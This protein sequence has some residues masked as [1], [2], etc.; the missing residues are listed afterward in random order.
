MTLQKNRPFGG[1][2]HWDDVEIGDAVHLRRGGRIEYAGRVDNRTADGAV[3]WVLSDGGRRQLFHVADG[4]ELIVAD[5]E[6]ARHAD[7]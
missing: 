3:V 7:N 4:F 6:G 2:A 1:P 5:P